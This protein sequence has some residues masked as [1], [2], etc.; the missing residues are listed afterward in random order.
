MSRG[1]SDSC[2]HGA[3]GSGPGALFPR[4]TR[5]PPW[6]PLS[7]SQ[8]QVP[9]PAP[10]V[11]SNG[12]AQAPTG[13]QPSPLRSEVPTPGAVPTPASVVRSSS[14]EQASP[15]VQKP[16]L[17]S[18]CIPATPGRPVMSRRGRVIIPPRALKDYIM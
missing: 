14:P 15:D 3:S 2:G 10:Q 4:P 16:T 13:R 18:S 12:G 9:V 7:A 8:L 11:M 1:G 17:V 5:P 6:K